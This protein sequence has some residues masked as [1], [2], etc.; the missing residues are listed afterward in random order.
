MIL[1]AFTLKKSCAVDRNEHAEK[2]K[3]KFFEF[4]LELGIS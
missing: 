4:E 1:V 2:I 3:K